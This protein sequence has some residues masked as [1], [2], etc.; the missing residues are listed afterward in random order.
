MSCS[1]AIVTG[2]C[3]DDTEV[4]CSLLVFDRFVVIFVVCVGA[5]FAENGGA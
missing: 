5:S 3:T 2:L 1:V 4:C